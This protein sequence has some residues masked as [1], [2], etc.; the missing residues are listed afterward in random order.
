MKN[1]S[2]I[3]VLSLL[4]CMFSCTVSDEDS[5]TQKPVV[6]LIAPVEGQKYEA[7][8]DLHFEM[9][10]SDNIGLASYNV[11]IHSAEGHT[12]G[13]EEVGDHGED[14]DHDHDHDSENDSRQSFKLNRTWDDS[15]GLKNDHVHNHEIVIPHDAKRGKYHFV[16]K[17]L[18]LSGNQTM[19]YR[20]IE[21][22]DL[23]HGDEEHHH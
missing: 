13:T 14:H 23:G 19:V 11:D 21:I 6:E 8:E 18:D 7:G 3:G 9:E 5:D 2:Y 16:V 20:T 10:I 17:V 1:I 15:Y 4:F 22:V 12:H